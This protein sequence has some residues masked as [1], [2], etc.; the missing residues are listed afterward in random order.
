[1]I[2][3]GVRKQWAWIV[4]FAL[5]FFIGF[6]RWY[7]GVHFPHDVIVGWLIGG[8]ILWAFIKYWDSTEIWLKQKS[9]GSQIMI[10]LIVSLGFVALGAV[11][12]GRLDGYIFP[13]AWQENALRPVELTELASPADGLPDPVSIESSITFAGVFFGM[14]MGAAWINARGGFQ[15]DG[16]IEKRALRFV[17]GLVGIVI[18]W[19]GLGE[20]FPDNGD[21]VSYVLR[22][23]RYALVGFWIFAGAPWLFFRIK[24]AK[25]NM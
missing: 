15:A 5:A 11:A 17:V 22:Y 18:I 10:A 8:V 2:A 7:L 23:V 1:M 24:L 21:L 25:S 19:M 13:D 12:V 20:V 14:A 16:P 6:S 9:L 4:A 3:S